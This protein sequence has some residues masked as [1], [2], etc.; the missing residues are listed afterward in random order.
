MFSIPPTI[1]RLMIAGLTEEIARIEAISDACE[2]DWPADFDPNDVGVYDSFRRFLEQNNGHNTIME[3]KTHSKVDRFAMSL[4]PQFVRENLD[5][6]SPADIESAC[7]VFAQ[8][9]AHLCLDA[10]D[11]SES[12]SARRDVKYL[13]SQVIAF[14]GIDNQQKSTCQPTEP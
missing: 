5:E 4:L 8:Y 12:S 1:S 14:P 2:D 13:L 10:L 9:V 6:L 11:D 3:M 7:R